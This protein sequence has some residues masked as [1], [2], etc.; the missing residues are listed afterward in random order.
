MN[1][2]RFRWDDPQRRI[3]ES[4]TPASHAALPTRVRQLAARYS[5]RL[6]QLTD[7]VATL[8]SRVEEHLTKMGA[9]WK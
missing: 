9:T 8:G 3:R 2:R 7:E 1:S 4:L 6:P 5:T